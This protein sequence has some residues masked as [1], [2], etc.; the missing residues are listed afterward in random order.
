MKKRITMVQARTGSSRFPGKV[1]QKALGRTALELQLERIALAK[2]TGQI[3]VVTT[4]ESSD[5]EIVRIAERAGYP[6]FRG[7]STDLLDRHFQAA[8]AFKA[9]EVAKIPSDCPLI[10]PAVIDQV[11]A[12]F[13]AEELD[14]CS[15]LHP[16]TFPDGNDVEVF[17]F[18]ALKTAWER[19]TKDFEREH[20]TPFLWERPEEFKLRNVVW[21]GG[22]DFSMSHRF[23]L[24]YPADWLFIH[25]VYQ[26]LYPTNPAFTLNQIL[27]FLEQNPE[28]FALNHQYAGVNW[29]RNHLNELRTVDSSMTKT[30]A[31]K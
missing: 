1:L 14:F 24:D 30:G 8:L 26:S 27:A 20:T 22:R 5:D 16:A 18:A 17:T 29:Y 9:E 12:A 6:V 10:D 2:K 7:H 21:E 28:V 23:T 4:Q 25:A 31:S 15:N 13:E 19:A 3:V 11:F